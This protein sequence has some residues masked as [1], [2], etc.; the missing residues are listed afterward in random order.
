MLKTVCVCDICG[1]ENPTKSGYKGPTLDISYIG[2]TTNLC[3][4]DA[5]FDIKPIL[6][7]AIHIDICKSC[8]DRISAFIEDMKNENI[9]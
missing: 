2:Y 9:P 7:K 1:K 8:A 3:C 5:T 6:D 4:V